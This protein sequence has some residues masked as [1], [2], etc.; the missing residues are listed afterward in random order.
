MPTLLVASVARRLRPRV[1]VFAAALLPRVPILS[2]APVVLVDPEDELHEFVHDA[3]AA[4][5][6]ARTPTRL[7]GEVPGRVVPMIGDPNP[8]SRIRQRRELC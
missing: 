3:H 5:S 8:R 6:R 4:V 1:F 2:V 7:V